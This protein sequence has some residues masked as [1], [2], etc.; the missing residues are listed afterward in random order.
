MG[1]RE[2]SSIQN[3]SRERRTF[4]TAH[5]WLPRQD[6]NLRPLGYEPSELPTALLGY[7]LNDCAYYSTSNWF[8]QCRIFTDTDSESSGRNTSV[9]A[10]Q[11]YRKECLDW[12]WRNRQDS[13]LRTD[14]SMNGL[15]I[16]GSTNYAYYSIWR[17]V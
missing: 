2:L 4:H 6:S 13:N 10:H 12:H 17:Q 5:L 11:I 16:R 3:A 9:V 15:A 8:C 7:I 14:Y 1:G